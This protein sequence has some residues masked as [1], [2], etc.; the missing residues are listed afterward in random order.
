[1]TSI[2]WQ[3]TADKI[4]GW[5]LA[6]GFNAIGITDINLGEHEQ[7]LTNWLAKEFHGEMSYMERHGAMRSH[8]E[9]LHRGT[10]SVITMR[11]DYLEHDPDPVKLID[12]PNKAYD[13]R[14]ALG[15]RL[16]N[17][18]LKMSLFK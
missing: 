3:V 13:S 16:L 7:H 5:A 1:M 10:R 8:P 9:Q 17:I 2:D 15:F 4:E 11:M 6:L 14:Y 18:C 12:H